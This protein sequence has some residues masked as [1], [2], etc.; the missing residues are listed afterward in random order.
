MNTAAPV[1]PTYN[2]VPIRPALG[3]APQILKETHRMAA[4]DA[5]KDMCMNG[6]DHNNRRR[7]SSEMDGH[8]NVSRIERHLASRTYAARESSKYASD[9]HESER[10]ALAK[11][12][13]ARDIHERRRSIDRARMPT[14]DTANR[15]D[16]TASRTNTISHPPKSAQK[17][18]TNH[19]QQQQQQQQEYPY[20]VQQEQ[21]PHSPAHHPPHSQPYQPPAPSH[22]TY[23]QQ[24][25]HHVL[26]APT[27]PLPPPPSVEP[28]VDKNIQAQT[29]APGPAPPSRSG[30]E[31]T[32]APPASGRQSR[33]SN[34][35]SSKETYKRKYGELPGYSYIGTIGQGNFGKVLL[36]EHDTTGEQVAVKILEKAQFKSEQQ[37][38]HATREARLMATL[39]HPYIVDV[40]TVL[41]DDARIMIVMEH[42]TGGELFDY[43][44]NKGV[45]D[46]KE[47]RRIFYQ[48]VLA[49]HYCHENNVVHRDLKP[50]NILLDSEKNVR[51]ADFGFGNHWHKDRH[52]TTYCGSPFYAAPEM[53]SG[54]P[55]I[56]PETDVWSLGVILYVLVCG[57]LPFDANDLPQLFAQIKR[58][59]YQK[60]REGSMDVCSLIH[61][62]LTVDPK[63]R[64][65]LSDVLRSRWLRNA[66]E[67]IATAVATAAATATTAT[68]VTTTTSDAPPSMMEVP[69]VTSVGQPT[70]ASSAAPPVVPVSSR[71]EPQRRST[72]HSHYHRRQ[73]TQQPQQQQQQQQQVTLTT[74]LNTYHP[75]TDISHTMPVPPPPIATGRE[76]HHQHRH[77]YS[78]QQQQHQ[79]QQIVYAHDLKDDAMSDVSPSGASSPTETLATISP[80][81]AGPSP[82][83]MCYPMVSFHDPIH[84]LPNKKHEPSS[85]CLPSPSSPSPLHHPSSTA[86]MASSSCAQS[87][88][89][90]LS[91]QHQLLQPPPSLVSPSSFS[92]T[93]SSS[94]STSSSVTSPVSPD[95]DHQLPYRPYPKIQP[96][97]EPKGTTT[98]RHFRHSVP[99]TSSSA[100]RVQQQLQTC[101]TTVVPSHDSSV[102]MT[103]AMTTDDIA[104]SISTS[105]D[106]ILLDADESSSGHCHGHGNGSS[107]S[108]SSN[109]IG[110]CGEGVAQGEGSGLESPSC[111][112]KRKTHLSKLR[113]FFKLDRREQNVR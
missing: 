92:S 100:S 85:P 5:I 32:P 62:M 98:P 94:P 110:G 19:H 63:R 6:P 80:R 53:V 33:L 52:L 28:M 72:V 78:S 68:T 43:I 58:G 64:A 73:Q 99:S 106:V 39:R 36:A 30:T 25:Q 86:S 34:T 112:K 70:S 20:L 75:N 108:T 4:H 3:N 77:S 2:H 104:I 9:V 109:D 8:S 71:P 102:S 61:R 88:T 101:A 89:S 24:Q 17:Y 7:K 57:R 60:P 22:Q 42:L 1:K 27:I 16:T 31:S 51:V 95:P 15:Y 74:A 82:T 18:C 48:I 41:E 105:S 76:Y 38:L 90:S 13:Q 23:S 113:H 21:S 49:L 67:P 55:Y 56:G 45:L 44:S 83:E 40:K 93:A 96:R 10:D 35:P 54:T 107:I 111:E 50:E 81:T 97:E 65:T 37:R 26:P 87:T 11:I 14:F 47:A 69:S 46:E 29:P 12:R 79:Q 91:P 66:D 59:N 103:M 84:P